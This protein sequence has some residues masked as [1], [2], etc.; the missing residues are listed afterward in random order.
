MKKIKKIFKN[1]RVIILLVFLVLAVVAIHPNPSAEGV[2]IRNVIPNSSASVAGIENPAPNTPPMSR[3]RILAIN[4]QSIKGLEDYFAI[5][6]DLRP[7]TLVT[8]VTNEDSYRLRTREAFNTTVLK[9]LELKEVPETYQENVTINGTVQTVNRTRNKT[10]LVNKTLQTP[11]GTEDIGLRVYEAPHT[12]I[13]KGLDLQGGT[14]VLLKPEE[15]ISDD[16]FN[17]L[18]DNMK[19]RLNVYG[20]SDIVIRESGDLFSDNRYITVEIAGVNEEEVKD[21]LSQQGKFEAMV[22][23]T[24]VFEGGEGDVTYVCRSAD[25]S[26]IDPFK[27]CGRVN[28]DQWACSFRFSITLKP[29][30]AERFAE[31]TED[32]PA[33]TTDDQGNVIPTDQQYLTEKIRLYLDDNFVDELN[34][35]ADLKGRAVTDIQ[36]SGSGVGTTEQE[37]AFNAL[38]NMKELQTI[39]VTGSLPTKIDIVKTDNLSPQLGQ[40]FVN[41]ALL[42]GALSMF[43]VGIVIYIRYRKAQIFV[44]M[45]VTMAS[46]VALLLGLASV[47]GWNLDLAA[48]AGIIIAVGTG[49]DDQIVITDETLR[50]ESSK[51]VNWK[52]R[53]KRAFFIIMAAYFTTCVAMVP[54]LFAGAGLLKGF[55]LTT[56]IGVS[57]G[58]FVTRPAFAAVIEI[59]LR[60]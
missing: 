3:E 42:I 32:I 5:V 52:K 15:N 35:G 49:V 27:G 24:T 1:P 60:D 44:P 14:R 4:S 48:I 31:A 37:A 13:R 11:L 51:Y 50:G 18:I 29:S 19:R 56:I 17:L 45:V 39:L 43:A 41:N 8:V 54:L 53:I 9:E 25:C 12:N 22:A 21:L 23:N 57:F 6:Q 46:E 10:V 36:I 38:A 2:A 40:E 33:R 58:V 34:I 47:I 26:G 7:D 59:L 28:G 16:K 55:A 20:L 30:A